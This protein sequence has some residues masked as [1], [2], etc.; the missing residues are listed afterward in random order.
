MKKILVPTDF[1]DNSLHAARYAATLAR[2]YDSNIVFLNV[3]KVPV[4]LEYDVITNTNSNIVEVQKMADLKLTD[5]T[6]NF[7][8]KTNFPPNRV[9]H[10][11][12]FG[13][14]TDTIIEKS[15]E[16]DIDMIVMGTKGAHNFF[17][18]WIGTNSEKVGKLAHCPVWIIPENAKLEYPQKILYAAD[19]KEN[20]FIANNKLLDIAKPIGASCKV[21]HVHEY[22]EPTVGDEI[23]KKIIELEHYF[24]NENISFKEINRPEIVKGLEKYIEGYNP[25]VIAFAMHEKSF[26]TKIFKSSISSHFLEKASR[27]ILTFRN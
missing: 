14:L 13:S 10:M 9:S 24:K 18:S 4:I 15:V 26:L 8:K 1:S 19:F 27:P 3:Y 25:D 11:S 12:E 16:T 5:F 23:N 20:E 22:S 7:I 17:D 6:D 21:V 2:V